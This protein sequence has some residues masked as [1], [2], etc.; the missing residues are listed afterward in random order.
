M[1]PAKNSPRS[2]L[3][4]VAIIVVLLTGAYFGN[5]ALQTHWGERALAETGLTVRSFTEASALAATAQKP[6]LVAHSAI[7]C[8]TCRQFDTKVLSDPAVRA[9][10]EKSYI[11][12]RVEFES[13]EGA[14]FREQYAVQGFPQVIVINP[15]GTLRKRLATTPM[16]PAAFLGQL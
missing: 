7:W 6:I 4:K 15:D 16:T 10:I 13:D 12:A 8:P 3:G 9:A 11:F 2:W 5:V 14:A 1:A